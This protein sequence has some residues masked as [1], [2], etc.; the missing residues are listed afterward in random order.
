MGEREKCFC[1]SHFT[2]HPSHCQCWSATVQADSS[3]SAEDG[4]SWDLTGTGW[5][6]RISLFHCPKLSLDYSP[7]GQDG[8]SDALTSLKWPIGTGLTSP[9]R[10]HLTAPP[11]VELVNYIRS[12]LQRNLGRV[13][14]NLH[15]CNISLQNCNIR[16]LQ[17]R[18]GWGSD[19]NEAM[20]N[21]VCQG[22]FLLWLGAHGKW[23][24][25]KCL[26]LQDSLKELK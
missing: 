17:I 11:T 21:K 14:E 20:A 8:R 3:M 4:F 10:S 6:E 18:H 19:D 5:F 22:M 23:P 1:F 16:L 9:H 25:I 7:Q 13:K 15:R 24:A 26:H 2:L 12:Y